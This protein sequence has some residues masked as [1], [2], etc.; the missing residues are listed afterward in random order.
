MTVGGD[1]S[2]KILEMATLNPKRCGILHGAMWFGIFLVRGLFKNM[3]IY[4]SWR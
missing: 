2:H 1:N 3:K 4:D